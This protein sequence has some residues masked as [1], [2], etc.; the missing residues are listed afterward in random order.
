M[1]VVGID[2]GTGVS[3]PT[4][5]VIFDSESGEIE[6]YKTIRPK[7]GAKDANARLRQVTE[8]IQKEA[9]AYEDVGLI[10]IETFVM[11]GI[12][13]QTLQRMIGAAIATSPE[14]VPLQEVYNTTVKRIVGGSGKA[15]KRD[16]AYGVLD[17]FTAKNDSSAEG[18]KRLIYEERFDELDA[19][20]IGIAGF[21][22][23]TGEVT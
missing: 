12:G 20:A 9:S 4:G 7:A 23:Y 11:R 19:F 13:G 6:K 17:W 18:I 15:D 2:P 3:S 1:K 21:L 10:C 14:R 16:V 8:Q 22:L 5:L